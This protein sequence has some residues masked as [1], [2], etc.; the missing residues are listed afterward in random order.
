MPVAARAP[1]EL[2]SRVFRG[3]AAIRSG[4][5]TPDQ[6]RAPVWRR[7]FRDVYVHRAVPDSHL[8]RARAAAVLLPG[9]VVT[10]PSAAVVWG[11]D[12]AGVDDDVE[13]TLPPGAHPRRI[14]GIRVRRAVLPAADVQRR[15]GLPVTTAE[16]T[17]VRLAALLPRDDAVVA[18]DRL[19]A[20]GVVDLAPVRAAAGA[21]RGPGSARARTVASLADGRAESPQESRLRLLMLRGGLPAPV[22]Q[23]SVRLDGRFVARVDFAWPDRKVAVEYDGLWHAEEGQFA[24]DRQR[25]NRLHAAGWRVVFVTAQDMHDPERLLALIAAALAS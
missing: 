16:A 3:S 12:L 2:L 4:L 11:L 17:A 19:I 24:R 10:G 1:E 15:K 8:L 22:P 20:T 9:A 25:L 21:A 14:T 5:L 13:I 18:V 7:L 23:F 6:L